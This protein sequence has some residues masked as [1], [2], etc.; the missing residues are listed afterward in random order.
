[1]RQIRKDT[2]FLTAHWLKTRRS[3]TGT[4]LTRPIEGHLHSRSSLRKELYVVRST[5]AFAVKD[6]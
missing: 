2:L 1:M 6:W 4:W 5:N 3:E